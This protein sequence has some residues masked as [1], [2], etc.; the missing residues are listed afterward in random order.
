MGR[1]LCFGTGT[2]FFIEAFLFSPLIFSL[3][4]GFK[5]SDHLIF[6]PGNHL[7]KEGL[8]WLGDFLVRTDKA[9]VLISH[10]ETLTSRIG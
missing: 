5:F 3:I 8:D 6:E 1:H 10:D 9:V 7:D 4:E 2:F